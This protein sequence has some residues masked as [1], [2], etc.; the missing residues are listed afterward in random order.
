MPELK[1]KISRYTVK[2]KYQGDRITEENLGVNNTYE[3]THQVT[4]NSLEEK[5][6][7]IEEVAYKIGRIS[8]NNREHAIE[9]KS[10]TY[11]KLILTKI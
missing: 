7:V 2:L 6:R 9:D 1:I 3:E 10:S 5:Q 8:E 11:N 4:S